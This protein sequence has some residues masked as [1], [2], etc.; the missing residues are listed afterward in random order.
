LYFG[1]LAVAFIRGSQQRGLA[2]GLGPGLLTPPLSD[3]SDDQ[4]DQIIQIG[5][6]A[7]LRLHRFKRTMGLRRVARVIGVLLGLGPGSLL[8]LGSGRGAFLWSLLDAIPAIPVTAIDLLDHRARDL[9]TVHLGGVDRL[10]VA[11]ASATRMPFDAD[12]FDGVTFLETLEHI[13][14]PQSALNEAVRIARRFIVLSVPSKP[15][16]NPE[17][18]HLFDRDTLRAMLERAGA[19]RVNFENVLNHLIAVARV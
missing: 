7:G 15:D 8:D 2:L 14:D 10:H 18:I 6:A 11:R 13:P 9:H 4:I 1:P 3:L 16:D 17:H 12:T 19:A 5:L